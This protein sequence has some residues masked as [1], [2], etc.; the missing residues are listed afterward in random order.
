[1][2]GETFQMP[3][4][5]I[6]RNPG[7]F[8]PFVWQL[9]STDREKRNAQ[10]AVRLAE[11]ANRNAGLRRTTEIHTR[12]EFPVRNSSR[13]ANT[14]NFLQSNEFQASG[15][16]LKDPSIIDLVAATSTFAFLEG[17]AA[18]MNDAFNFFAS[19][20]LSR[21]LGQFTGAGRAEA[22]NKGPRRVFNEFLSTCYKSI[23]KYVFE[24]IMTTKVG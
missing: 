9:F 5:F 4:R 23:P 7:L 16:L 8:E 20:H 21:V 24:R 15:T 3:Q 13:Y 6:P 14:Y 11:Y 2:P 10:I 17:T 18:G 12:T 19:S 1:M 22:E